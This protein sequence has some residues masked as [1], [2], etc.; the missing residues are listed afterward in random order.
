M[1]CVVAV[2]FLERALHMLVKLIASDNGVASY[3]QG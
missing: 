2:S 1:F 3:E